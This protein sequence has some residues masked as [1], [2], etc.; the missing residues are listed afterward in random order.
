MKVKSKNT[1]S[2]RSIPTVALIGNPNTGKTTLFNALTGLMQRT[3]NFPGVTV[4]KKVGTLHIG[5]RQVGL[6]DLPGTY[7]LAANSP[8][9]IV[10]TDVLLGQQEGAKLPDAV[11]VVADA[12]NLERNLYLVTQVLECGR[13]VILALN[14]YDLARAKGMEIDTQTLGR[15][16]GCQVVCV[17]ANKGEGIKELRMAIEKTLDSPASSS[18]FHIDFG[19]PVEGAVREL[20]HFFAVRG[21]KL[22]R[23]VHRVEA[24][25]TLIDQ[26]GEAERR[27]LAIL[28]DELA[29]VL[30]QLRQRVAE[31]DVE[32]VVTEP[33]AR[34]ER[35]GKLVETCIHRAVESVQRSFSDRVDGLLTHPIGGMAVFV[36]LMAIVFQAIYSWAGPLMDSID[37][38]FSWL[39]N[40]V[41]TLMPPGALQSLIVDGAIAGVG[42][43]VIFLPQIVIL[44]GFI[45]ILEDCGYMARAAFLMDRL[46]SWVGLSGRS[47]VPMLSSFA[48]AVPGVMATRVIENRRDRF[49]TILV[50]P[51]MS[52]S[53]RLPVYIIMIAAFIPNHKWLGGWLG[54]QGAVLFSMYMLG[55]VVAIP[56]AWILKKTLLKGDTP[57][58]VMEMPAY[59]LPDWRTVSLRMYD[60]GMAFLVRAGT[61]IFAVTI[62][63]WGAAYF[64]RPQS[65]A[66]QY[67]QG[68]A[69]I[70]RQLETHVISEAERDK[71][72]QANERGEAGAY[73]RQ[74]ILGRMGRFI[75]P[76]VKP[77]GWDWKIGMATI[78]SFP[79]REV[80]VATLGTIYNMGSDV[81]ES[82]QGLRE[83]MKGATW[84]DGRLVFTP[85]V[86]LSI[87][88]FFALCC[89][90]AS[91][92]AVIQRETGSWKWPALTFMYM[93][94]LAYL[95]ALITYQG[96]KLLGG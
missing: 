24:L 82:S 21:D 29:D 37:G 67:A 7:S 31:V 63:V 68:A 16:L 27:M 8:D 9:E 55:I 36:A 86:A 66:E 43:V 92:L 33:E 22:A 65:I 76:I 60:R 74:S 15:A 23:P 6:I 56:V 84:P 3:G 41:S 77:L 94:T 20:L 34:Y 83:A 19:G 10:A 11:I 52:C 90:C 2:F 49:A 89:Q 64:P 78:A 58:F 61:T 1:E 47:F 12:S 46:M 71:A 59:K 96:G 40:Q 48:C 4:E 73:L 39:G 80:I 35:I 53:A 26:G 62:L 85:L 69:A 30:A 51:L 88:V 44:F 5:N 42:S 50:V 54:L 70:Q 28:G 95:G 25:R 72:L 79:A 45:A 32:L 81:D 93:T 75:E 87:M 17:V 57:P 14:M 91:T 18:V 38:L 13:P